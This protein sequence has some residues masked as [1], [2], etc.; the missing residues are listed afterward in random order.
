MLKG[1]HKPAAGSGGKSAGGIPTPGVSEALRYPVLLIGQN[2]L[3]VRDSEEELITTY[4][5]ASLNFVE[6]VILDSDGRLFEVTD[7]VPEPGG[8]S[9]ILDMG[10]SPRRYAVTLREKRRSEW[11]K[12]RQLL[13]DQVKAP[14][15]FWEGD[16]KAVA[17]VESLNSV[18]EAIEACRT[19]WEWRR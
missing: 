13:L 10:T 12:V 5:Y 15:S 16:A 4:G 9:W 8:K 2:A 14:N 11:P 6:R 17:K 18:A 7:A 19:S 1:C 3:D